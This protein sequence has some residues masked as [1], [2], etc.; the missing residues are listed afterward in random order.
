MKCI[1]SG[2]ESNEATFDKR[3]H[4]FPAGIGG[5]NML[6]QGDVSDEI[7]EFFSKLELQFMR[8]SIIQIPRMFL[9]PGKRGSLN[10]KKATKSK[11][12]LMNNEEVVKIGYIELGVPKGIT[13][14]KLLKENMKVSVI[15]ELRDENIKLFS[16]FEEVLKNQEKIKVKKSKRLDKNTSIVGFNH[17]KKDEYIYIY[18]NYEKYSLE[19]L[20]QHFEEKKIFEMIKSQCTKD[21]LTISLEKGLQISNEMS[22]NI[23]DYFRICCKIAINGL[24]FLK[25]KENILKDR[26]WEIKDFILNGG[27]N[28]FCTFLEIKNNRNFEDTFRKLEIPKFCHFMIFLTREDGVY[29][30]LGI[31]G[32]IHQIYL[33]EKKDS[34]GFEGGLICDWQNKK[35]YNFNEYLAEKL[36]DQR[37]WEKYFMSY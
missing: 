24:C 35:E 5:I 11:I 33:C 1:Y 16:K 21:N 2:K 12:F 30:I 34:E 10:K 9:G 17:D 4:V 15:T 31:Y 22:F 19:N 6:N 37:I 14:I 28:K 26:F 29:C 18:H 23:D 7:N 13:Q 32:L 36:Q 20:I 27:E 25:G 3:E 8:E